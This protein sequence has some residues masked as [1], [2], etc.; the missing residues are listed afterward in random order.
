MKP[1]ASVGEEY[2][3][4]PIKDLRPL[5]PNCHAVIHLRQPPYSIEEVKTMLHDAADT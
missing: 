1:L 4:D 2:V 3:I 5:C